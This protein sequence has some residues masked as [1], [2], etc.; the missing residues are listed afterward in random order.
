MFLSYSLLNFVSALT[1]VFMN[2]HS[3]FHDP[4]RSIVEKAAE[5]T[6]SFLLVRST[7]S[8]SYWPS[9]DR[10]QTLEASAK[11]AAPLLAW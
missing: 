6:E 1:L 11:M 5:D 3:P 10:R 7:S 2:F 8:P 4:L 9:G